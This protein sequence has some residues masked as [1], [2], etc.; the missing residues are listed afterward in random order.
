MDHRGYDLGRSFFPTTGD[1]PLREARVRKG[2]DGVGVNQC[3]EDLAVYVDGK[4]A[5]W[6]G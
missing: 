1:T 6:V 4:A 3:V 2:A 5:A